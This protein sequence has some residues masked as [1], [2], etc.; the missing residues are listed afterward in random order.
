MA[1]DFC[2]GYHKSHNHFAPQHDLRIVIV[3]IVHKK[4]LV[5]IKE[6]IDIECVLFP[7]L[8]KKLK[9]F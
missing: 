1:N 6:I 3:V 8:E 2:V 7:F 9:S 5:L 4:M